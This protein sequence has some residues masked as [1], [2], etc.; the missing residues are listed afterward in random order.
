MKP[1]KITDLM[2]LEEYSKSRADFSTNIIALKAKRQVALGNNI[3]LLFENRSTILYQVQEMLRIERIFEQDS[4][5]EELSVYNPLI[6]NGSNLK[7]TMMIEYTDVETRKN[8]LKQLIGIEKLLYLQIADMGKITPVTNEDLTRDNNEK[9]S[10]VHFLRFELN[11]DEISA[12]KK[13]SSVVFG[14]HHK[15]YQAQNKIN[16]KT[17]QILALDFK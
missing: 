8:K 6:P 3:R 9:T 10:S 11:E 15:Y 13:G 16:S 5:L 1:I 4:I 2:S 12:F 14:C 17:Q 7:A